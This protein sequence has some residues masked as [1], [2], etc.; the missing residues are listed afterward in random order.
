MLSVPKQNNSVIQSPWGQFCPSSVQN[1]KK[2]PRFVESDWFA[3]SFCLGGGQRFLT[4]WDKLPV[5]V[6]TSVFYENTKQCFDRHRFMRKHHL[7]KTH[8]LRCHIFVIPKV[9]SLPSVLN[10]LDRSSFGIKWLSKWQHIWKNVRFGREIHE[11]KM[12]NLWAQ[13]MPSCKSCA[14]V[15]VIELSCIF[16]M[17]NCTWFNY[18]GEQDFSRWSI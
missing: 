15:C 5:C 8:S 18:H 7:H 2:Y 9:S 4:V 11:L 6:Q 10:F 1:V 13:C 14:C 17:D 3:S 12:E 16:V